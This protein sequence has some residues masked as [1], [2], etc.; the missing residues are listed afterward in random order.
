M[1][2]GLFITIITA[3]ILLALAGGG[4]LAYLY[5]QDNPIEKEEIKIEET[6]T[7]LEITE[8]RIEEETDDL[9]INVRYPKTNSEKVNQE[10][11]NLIQLEI[12]NFKESILDPIEGLSSGIYITYITSLN[13]P[14]FLS[15]IFDISL[16]NSGA[17]HPIS[18]TKVFNYDLNEEKRIEAKNILTNNYLEVLSKICIE[19]LI[20]KIEPDEFMLETINNGAGPLEENYQNIAF[21]ENGLVVIFEQYQVAAYALGKQSIEISNSEISD[22]LK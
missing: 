22:I 13:S 10:I 7:S 12:N 14:H 17:A 3:I 21:N 16:Y 4:Y 11:D 6:K 2:K 19:K 5:F 9:I 18:I 20:K 15:I 1:T 8:K